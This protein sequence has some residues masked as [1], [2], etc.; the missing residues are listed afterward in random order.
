MKP[1]RV[2]TGEIVIGKPLA[3][4]IYDDDGQLLLKR[5]V[6]ITADDIPKSIGAIVF[7]H[8]QPEALDR[9]VG[10]ERDGK[11]SSD[12]G[13]M[14]HLKESPFEQLALLQFSLTALLKNFNTEKKF[15]SKAEALAAIVEDVCKDDED[16]AL[17]TIM[18]D[19]L[20]RYS[21]RHQIHTAIVCEVI[22]KRLGWQPC[23][24]H[25]LIL[26][27]LTM[28]IGMLELHDAL[29]SQ[30]SPLSNSQRAELQVHPVAG[31]EI[32]QSLGVADETW[33]TAV[34]QHHEM[35]DGTGY[36][37]N[38]RERQ[39][40]PAAQILSLAD[41]YCARVSGRDYRPP[42]SPVN[43]MREIFLSGK[44]DPD[45]GMLFIKHIGIFPPGTF[46]R[47][48]NGEVAVVT[49]RGGKTNCPVVYTVMRSGGSVPI[50][51]PRR[52]TSASEYAITAVVPAEKAGVEVNRYQLWGYG[53]FKRTKAIIR[54]EEKILVSI[55]AKLLDIRTITTMDAAIINLNES[56]CTLEILHEAGGYLKVGMSLHMTFKIL[57]F[58]VENV[59]ALVKNV[60]QK[61]DVLII[62]LKFTEISEINKENIRTFIKSQGHST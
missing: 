13:A 37:N 20:S 36:P 58:I 18:L 48:K 40:S 34:L 44:I 57:T 42:L 60:Q 7:E 19:N 46:V 17:G 49:Q 2:K 47:L 16:L 9:T 24:R 8:E 14:P 12:D 33:L 39:I 23:E 53:V 52:D 28:N 22:A 21:I 25:P 29:H 55:P 30:E 5:G 38:L 4:S 59:T 6:T 10:E 3:A 62:E 31:A 26:A 61:P 50:V 41:T 27:A 32:L 1:R 45:L 15:S 54:K 51:P 11:K 56:G 43:A 35:P